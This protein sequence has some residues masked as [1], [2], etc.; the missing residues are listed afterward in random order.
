M[1][2]SKYNNPNKKRSRRRPSLSDRIEMQARASL[3][4]SRLGYSV[5]ADFY[6]RAAGVQK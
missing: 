6:N 4:D 3:I 1:R 2:F 5:T